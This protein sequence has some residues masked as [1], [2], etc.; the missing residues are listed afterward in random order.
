MSQATDEEIHGAFSHILDL[1]KRRT[2]SRPQV[3]VMKRLGQE[4]VKISDNLLKKDGAGG[5]E[6]TKNVG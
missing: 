6:P 1:M 3:E 2:F 4:V 5:Q